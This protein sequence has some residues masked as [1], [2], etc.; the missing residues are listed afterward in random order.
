MGWGAIAGAVIGGV[1]ANKAAKTQ[2][3]AIDRANAANNMAFMDARKYINPMYQMGTD[4]MQDQ[5]AAGYYSGPTLATLNDMQTNAIDQQYNYGQNAFGMA[6]NQMN[7]AQN[8]ANNYNALYNQAG[9]DQIGNAMQYANDNSQPLVDAALRDSTR[10]LEENTL[11]SIGMGAS[12]SGNQ[13]SSRAGVAEAIAGRDYL[14]RAADTAA[15]IKDRLAKDYL[16]QSQNQFSNQM[17]ANAGLGTAFNTAFGMGNTAT[18]NMINAG[19]MY[20]KDL[21]NQYN[22]ARANFEGNRDFKS[23]VIADYN[24]QILKGAP[25]TPGQQ[26]ANTVDPTAAALSGAIAGYGTFGQM[27]PGTPTVNPAAKY[28]ANPFMSMAPSGQYISAP[29]YSGF[30]YMSGR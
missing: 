17:A 27:F 23:N 24:A 29:G 9:Q 10:N 12:S 7:Q 5:L 3:G 15:S 14:D 4:A 2:A 20:Q 6:N 22:D 11:R 18:S 1:M 30:G 13:N 28:Q 26:V 21:Q 25:R 16:T 19:S 8:Y